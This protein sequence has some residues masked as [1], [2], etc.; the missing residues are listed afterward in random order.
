M[1]IIFKIMAFSIMLNIAIGMMMTMFP[2]VF[3]GSLNPNVGKLYYENGSI[4]TINNGMRQPIS[5]NGLLEDKGNNIYRVLDMIGIGY[6]SKILQYVDKY[7]FGFVN[8][9]KA[10]FY[11][12][13]DI[14][15]AR[16][17]FGPPVGLLK[18]LMIFGYIIGGIFMWTGKSLD[19]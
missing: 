8:L 15:M 19:E 2:L 18:T 13:L 14:G 6:I 3:G 17:L 12:Y 1:K 5:P 16:F 11:D 4:D 9:L 10:M 7:T